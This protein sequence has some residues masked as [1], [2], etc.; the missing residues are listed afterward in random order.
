MNKQ[1]VE[2]NAARLG[3]DITGMTWNEQ[4]STVAKAMASEPR[5]KISEDEVTKLKR[6]L[7]EAKA[8]N[9]EYQIKYENFDSGSAPTG[10]EL[11]NIPIE[12][13]PL[14]G[15]E[16]D[17]KPKY[18]FEEEVGNDVS[19]HEENYLRDGIPQDMTKGENRSGTFKHLGYKNNKVI[20]TTGG[21]L[22]NA[23][24]QWDPEALFPIVYS[25][26]QKG[27]LWTA[28]RATL[29]TINGGYYL[30]EFDKD[31][32]GDQHQRGKLF[33]IM[34]RLALPIEFGNWMFKEIE[35]R[36]ARRMKEEQGGY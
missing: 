5:K 4:V 35:K 26:T 27:Y 24:I 15:A 20:A 9:K 31:I 23:G 32:H 14:I 16:G 11:R 2:A 7:A 17:K 10:D 33:S 28:V 19:Y 21:P 6:E 1:E 22:R 25:Q 34:N 12:I 18:L 8:R 29:L 13:A 3:I 36:E 30:T